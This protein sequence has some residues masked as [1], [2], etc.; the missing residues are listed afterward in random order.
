MS[1]IQPDKQDQVYESLLNNMFDIRH[2]KSV[3]AGVHNVRDQI[4]ATY[5]YQ[6]R[7][8]VHS[9]GEADGDLTW[10]LSL[11]EQEKELLKRDTK[12]KTERY[13]MK[14]EGPNHCK[15]SCW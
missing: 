13:W 9:I 7:F 12:S 15:R 3:V 1:S 14:F 8:E 2:L 11:T 6:P 10:Y 4:R 5:L